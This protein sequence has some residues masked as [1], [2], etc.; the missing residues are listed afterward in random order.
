LR[1]RG[2]A[3]RVAKQRRKNTTSNRKSSCRRATLNRPPQLFL[4][5]SWLLHL[6]RWLRQLEWVVNIFFHTNLCAAKANVTLFVRRL[7]NKT[8]SLQKLVENISATL[9]SI[10]QVLLKVKTSI[11]IVFLMIILIPDDE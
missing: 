2:C 7:A 11:P 1:P 5:N 9:G 6:A 3:G 4:P 8:A 10:H